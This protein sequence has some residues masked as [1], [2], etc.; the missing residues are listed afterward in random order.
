[1]NGLLLNEHRM[2]NQCAKE[3]ATK[4]LTR[5]Y[6]A[7]KST[8]NQFMKVNVRVVARFNDRSS[9]LIELGLAATKE[10][11]VAEANQFHRTILYAKDAYSVE[12]LRFVDLDLLRQSLDCS[13]SGSSP[14]RPS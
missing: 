9:V 12:C 3:Y 7:M 1:M 6:D 8:V 13:S 14:P 2:F 5:D 11:Y 10:Q 4:H